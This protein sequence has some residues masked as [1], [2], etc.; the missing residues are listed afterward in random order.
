MN[1]IYRSLVS[2]MERTPHHLL[3]EIIL[4]G[5]LEF[6]K[7]EKHFFQDYFGFDF[8]MMPRGRSL[9]Q[10]FPSLALFWEN[11]WKGGAELKVFHQIIKII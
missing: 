7:I 4:V 1:I 3:P 11:T 2:L 5:I 10:L 6:T 9:L 8:Q